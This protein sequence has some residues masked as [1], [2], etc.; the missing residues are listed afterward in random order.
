MQ[1]D[2]SAHATEH[3]IEVQLPI[4]E[5]LT[6]A[7]DRPQ[8]TAVVVRGA[9]WEEIERASSQL[10]IVLAEQK[11]MPLLVISSDMNHYE[12]EQENR[13]RD[14]LA[15]EAMLSGDP[16]H[17]VEVCQKNAISMCGLVPAAI[18]MQTLISMGKKFRVERVSYEN[19][20]GR[21]GDKNRVVGYAG[22]MIVPV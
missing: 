20:A 11:T 1:L 9:T 22:M 8:L 18:V 17:L 21:G 7:E 15:I 19:S 14:E 5:G 4:L 12:S 16:K 2:S 3:G 10:A 6:T 13:R